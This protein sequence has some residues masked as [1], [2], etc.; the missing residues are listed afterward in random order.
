LVGATMV[1]SFSRRRTIMSF[2]VRGAVFIPS[3]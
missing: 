3:E 2:L 1:I